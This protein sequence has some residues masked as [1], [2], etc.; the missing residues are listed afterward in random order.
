MAGVVKSGKNKGRF[1]PVKGSRFKGCVQT[2]ESRGKSADS[3]KKICAFI[4]RRKK[5][6]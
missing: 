6:G 3:A 4:A 2:Q 5:G 1:K